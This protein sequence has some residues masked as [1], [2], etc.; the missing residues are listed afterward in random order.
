MKKIISFV[1]SIIML[2]SM[3]TVVLAD[4]IDGPKQKPI[5]T[6]GVNAEFFPFEYYEDEELK[7]FDIELM[8]RIGE[9]IG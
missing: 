7:G 6:V 1:L 4:G 5:L 3:A 2:L 8:N 9:K